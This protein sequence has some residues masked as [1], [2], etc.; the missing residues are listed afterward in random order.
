LADTET[1]DPIY[2]FSVTLSLV[3]FECDPDAV[4]EHL[5]LVPTRIV[6]KG[7]SFPPPRHPD[8]RAR[9]NCWHYRPPQAIEAAPPHHIEMNAVLRPFRDA[10]EPRLDQ[11]A[12]LPSCRR[13]DLSVYVAP[14]PVTPSFGFDPESLAFLGRLGLPCEIDI[15]NYAPDDDDEP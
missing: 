2:W 9:Y 6:R 7:Q 12:T 11:V 1:S 8:Y 10:L 13:K 14:N 3:G 4:T 15:Q 5:G